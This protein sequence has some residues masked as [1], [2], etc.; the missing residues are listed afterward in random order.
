MW[1]NNLK[2]LEDWRSLTRIAEELEINKSVVSHA[3]KTFGTIDISIRKTAGGH[4]RKIIAVEDRFII[5]QNLAYV[6]PLDSDEG[7]I[8]RI[9]ETAACVR[10]I[11]EILERVRQSLYRRFQACFDNGGRNFEQLLMPGE[12]KLKLEEVL[13]LFQHL[14]SESSDALRDALKMKKSQQIISWYFR[15]FLGRL[16]RE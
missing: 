5:L 15:K 1:K 9:S 11:P 16:S 14:P 13:D 8:V 12:K 6:T 2:K 10:E 3:W 4:P 7:L